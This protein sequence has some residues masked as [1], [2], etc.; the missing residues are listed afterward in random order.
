MAT[1]PPQPETPLQEEAHY[2]LPFILT[3]AMVFLLVIGVMMLLFSFTY[4]QDLET[5]R[6]VPNLV[7]NFACGQPIESGV[8]LPLLLTLTILSFLTTGVLFGVQR[9][10]LRRAATP[11]RDHE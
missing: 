6:N 2:D 1:H 10:L 11:G 8:T 5:L 3:I 4:I 9:W 7:W